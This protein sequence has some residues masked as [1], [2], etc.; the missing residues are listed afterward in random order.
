MPHPLLPDITSVAAA[1]AAAQGFELA[2]IQILTHLQPMTVQ[3]QIR[4]SDGSD[5]SLDDCAGFSRPM[6]EALASQA[7]LT[8]AY[9]LEISSPGIGDQL[10]SDRD[11]QTFRSYPVEV[12]YRDNEGKELRQQGSLLE[13]DN[14]HV[15]VNV[16][17][18]IKR[19]SRPSVISVQLISPTS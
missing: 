2:G 1:T 3:V 15:H 9:V 14:D 5:V 18:R 10:Q 7:L 8:E 17:G 6:G 13:R 11:F 16:R 19:I 4:R 12:L